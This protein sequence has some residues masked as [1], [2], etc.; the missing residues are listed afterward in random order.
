[1]QNR[2]KQP[3]S[4]H[5]KRT[6]NEDFPVLVRTTRCHEQRAEFAK[7]GDSRNELYPLDGKRSLLCPVGCR[8]PRNNKSST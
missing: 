3:L 5:E 7:D 4:V 6:W 2:Q 8:V 1:M